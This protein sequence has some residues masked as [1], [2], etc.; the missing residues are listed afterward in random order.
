M[1]VQQPT[2]DPQKPAFAAI[3]SPLLELLPDAGAFASNVRR[4]K[5]I[6]VI[7]ALVLSLVCGGLFA[8]LPL[9]KPSLP[10]AR[11]FKLQ[12]LFC[13]N[14]TVSRWDQQFRSLLDRHTSIPIKRNSVMT[15]FPTKDYVYEI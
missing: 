3:P 8:E 13:S 15:Q 4:S 14:S 5:F 9:P 10:F 12:D 7:W 11:N 6:G 2:S 1:A